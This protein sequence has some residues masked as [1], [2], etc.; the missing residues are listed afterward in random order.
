[1]FVSRSL[2]YAVRALIHLALA[3]PSESVNLRELA[4]AAA[5]PRS[6]LAKVMRMLVRS[7]LVHSD[8]GA[9]G[10]Y[11][12]ARSAADI[13]L[14]DIYEAVEGPFQTVVCISNAAV[15]CERLD[16]CTQVSVWSSLE[17][18]IREL[19]TQRSLAD[20]VPVDRNSWVAVD[21]IQATQPLGR[22]AQGA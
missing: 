18:E 1:M 16:D 5:V 15:G 11:R 3:A 8:A 7:Q 9:H 12:L 20:F 21:Q 4:D 10:G 6:Y 14:S 13:R 2:D 17:Q 19:L 22:A